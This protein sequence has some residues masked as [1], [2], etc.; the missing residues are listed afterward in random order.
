MYLMDDRWTENKLDFLS[1]ILY[2]GMLEYGTNK[3]NNKWL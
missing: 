3:Q 2:F 1:L